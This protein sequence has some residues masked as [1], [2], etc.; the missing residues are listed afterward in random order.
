MI[1]LPGTWSHDRNHDDNPH[2]REDYLLSHEDSPHDH[3]QIPK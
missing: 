1:V 2:N 3:V